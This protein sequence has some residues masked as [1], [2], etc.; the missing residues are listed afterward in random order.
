MTKRKYD[1]EHIRSDWRTGAYTLRDLA[2]KHNIGKSTV[3]LTVKGVEKDN[4]SIVDDKLQAD[5]AIRMLS[6]KNGQAVQEVV[7]KENDRRILNEKMRAQ[8]DKG[9]GLANKMALAILS[10]DNATM[11]DVSQYGKFQNDARVGLDLQPK[12]ANT[13]INNTNA[14][15][16]NETT[17][18]IR[19]AELK[20][21]SDEDLQK[22]LQATKDRMDLV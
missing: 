9:V 22:E 13:T 7:K 4:A 15:Q 17:S 12:F 20:E 1:K 21:M 19:L 18:T 2:Y 14:Q 6:D 16:N 3:A 10:R 8:L 11:N 5:Q